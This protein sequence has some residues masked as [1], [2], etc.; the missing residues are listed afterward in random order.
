VTGFDP[1]WRSA[2]ACDAE[3]RARPCAGM[4]NWKELT[5]YEVANSKRQT[6]SVGASEAKAPP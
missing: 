5:L 3:C 2:D 4:D 6:D 1:Q